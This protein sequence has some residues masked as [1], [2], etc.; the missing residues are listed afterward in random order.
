MNL[1]NNL[2]AIIVAIIPVIGAIVLKYMEQRKKKTKR[3]Q[4]KKEFFS[5]WFV[6]AALIVGLILGFIFWTPPPLPDLPL[7]TFDKNTEGW[8][9]KYDPQDAATDVSWDGKNEALQVKFDFGQIDSNSF[10]GD[11]QPRATFII[12]NLQNL[13]WS[14]Y[15]ILLVD[16]KN[17]E[18]EFLELAFSVYVNNCYYEFDGYANI[19]P[20]E[21]WTTIP[22]AFTNPEYKTCNAPIGKVAPVI[23]DDV[24]RFD[25]IIGTNQKNWNKLNGTILIDNVRLQ[26]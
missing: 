6:L 14:D 12:D 18:T 20:A 17:T 23:F 13:S 16:I 9:P 1:D 10:S 8:Y 26:K 11:E 21:D 24:Q 3:E 5:W 25:I 2:T 7:W 19:P 22:F 15:K 4:N